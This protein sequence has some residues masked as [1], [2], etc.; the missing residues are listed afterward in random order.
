MGFNSAFKG[1]VSISLLLQQ[2]LVKTL[3][4]NYFINNDNNVCL[5]VQMILISV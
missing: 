4:V 3:N 1:L 5:F 2:L